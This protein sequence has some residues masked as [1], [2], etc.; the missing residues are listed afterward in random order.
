MLNNMFDSDSDEIVISSKLDQIIKKEDKYILP[1]VLLLM[2]QD[3]FEYFVKYE[4]KYNNIKDTLFN[5][6]S[7]IELAQTLKEDM[8]PFCP[9]F[10]EALTLFAKVSYPD[11]FKETENLELVFESSLRELVFFDSDGVI[12]ITFDNFFNQAELFIKDAL[13]VISSINI[14]S[15]ISFHEISEIS[16]RLNQEYEMF[17]YDFLEPYINLSTLLESIY[18]EVFGILS[19][20]SI[21]MLSPEIN[22]TLKYTKD[23]ISF[24]SF[25]IKASKSLDSLEKNNDLVNDLKI[26]AVKHH[27]K[28]LFITIE[29]QSCTT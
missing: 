13:D 1:S 22:A 8:W 14:D 12:P 15:K 28:V 19:K 11:I 6:K 10:Q 29:M 17:R 26:Y 20:L 9:F 24:L 2:L 3:S 4:D 5:N 21:K 27:Q 25:D 23:K 7:I 18:N 16:S